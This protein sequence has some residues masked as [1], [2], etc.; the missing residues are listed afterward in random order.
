MPRYLRVTGELKG[1]R[2]AMLAPDAPGKVVDAPIERG[3][4]VAAGDVILKLDDRAATLTLRE[5][6]ASRADAQLK[7]DWAHA[8]FTRN[9]TL[10]KQR[11]IAASE[12]EQFKL[13]RA[14]ADTALAAA[15][16][17][18]DSAKKALD[19]TVLRAP[20]GGAVVERL[21]EVGEFV[22]TSTGVARLV[23]TENLRLVVLVPE[24]AVGGIH[25]GQAVSF[26]VPAFA[27]E[28]FVGTVKFIGAALRESSRDLA[29]EAEVRN[30]SGKLKP[31]MFAE[32]RITLTEVKCLTVPATA[33]RVDG[34]T[35]K[36][37]VIRGGL[38]DER[39]VE[40]GE[41]RGEAVEIRRG[42][43]EGDAVLIHPGTEATDGAKVALAARL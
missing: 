22:N 12:F 42:L 40:V 10:S 36:V 8:E 26:T 39:V 2:Q 23:A 11:L 9:E 33:L 18:R 7:L 4:A 21:T 15:T 5:A 27:D 20:F 14:T 17:R 43:V 28:T 32:G 25:A 3:S 34:G 41:T 6:E 31:G 16:A 19:D 30:A 29:I 24:V 38:M 35:H 1:A 37:F 13:N